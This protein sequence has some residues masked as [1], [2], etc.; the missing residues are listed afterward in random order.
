MQLLRLKTGPVPDNV[1]YLICTSGSYTAF[2]I[3]LIKNMLVV[4]R[5]F[6]IF[7]G[8]ILPTFE[9]IAFNFSYLVL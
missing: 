4:T 1:C 5:F 2:E 7:A 9:K 3:F 8:I 6:F